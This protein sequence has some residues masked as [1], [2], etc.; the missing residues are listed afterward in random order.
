MADFGV[1]HRNEISGALSG[2][3]RVR[4]FQQDDAHI[5]C[6]P[7]QVSVLPC[8]LIH[9][10]CDQYSCSQIEE[11]IRGC[12]DFLDHVYK[13]FG[14][15][16]KLYLSTRPEKFIGDPKM[17]EKAEAVSEGEGGGEGKG[18]GRDVHLL[19]IYMQQLEQS[20]KDFGHPWQLNPG[21][22]AFYGPKVR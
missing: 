18:R 22:G 16:F 13:V 4:R 15:T 11:E 9:W 7:D 20:L 6:T 10:T 14:F 21:D 17:W 12:L 3:T 19:S 1:L 8:I 5:F 2:L